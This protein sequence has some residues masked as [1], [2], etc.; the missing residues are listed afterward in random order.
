MCRRI[1]E[2]VMIRRWQHRGR[3]ER[4]IVEHE[5]LLVGIEV[6][7]ECW[8]RSSQMDLLT[9]TDLLHAAVGGVV[10]VR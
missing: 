3:I 10:A 2:V 8:R 6:V 7:A 5:L 4:L 9:G 1:V